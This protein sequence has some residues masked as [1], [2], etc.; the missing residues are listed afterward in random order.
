MG[1]QLLIKLR[2][3]ARH[4]VAQRR[5]M[6]TGGAG[7]VFLGIEK[8]WW[9]FAQPP[10]MRGAVCGVTGDIVSAVAG[11]VSFALTSSVLRYERVSKAS[12]GAVDFSSVFSAV[13]T[14]YGVLASLPPADAG[15]STSP[16]CASTIWS[17]LRSAVASSAER[18]RWTCARDA[19]RRR[20]ECSNRD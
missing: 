5:A 2:Y 13:A 10:W 7:G 12:L 14:G 17:S 15:S 9:L 6:L 16:V 4:R 19:A 11:R 1:P 20:F 8:P 18:S 3:A